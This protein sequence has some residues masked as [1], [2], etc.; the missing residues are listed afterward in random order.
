[1]TT[2]LVPELPEL[3]GAARAAARSGAGSHRLD[4]AIERAA[5][6]V[7][8]VLLGPALVLAARAVPVPVLIPGA[9]LLLVVAVALARDTASGDAATVAA[10]GDPGGAT[11]GREDVYD[12]L[13]CHRA[14]GHTGAH[15]DARSGRAFADTL[16][17]HIGDAG[18]YYRDRSGRPV[19]VDD[20][21]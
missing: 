14:A 21:F 2:P 10:T 15:G 5:V 3:P 1:M 13:R 18:A 4:R 9:L 12:T 20:A 17:I 19:P 16:D 6:V 7:L 8:L 11:C